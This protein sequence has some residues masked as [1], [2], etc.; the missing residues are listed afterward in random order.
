MT[1][2]DKITQKIAEE[3][4]VK[5]DSILAEA[6]RAAAQILADGRTEADEKAGKIIADANAEANR[7]TSAAKAKAESI[8]RTKY[9]EV[10]NAVVNDVIAAAFE[11]VENMDDEA[12][13]ALLHKLCVKNIEKGECELYL[14]ARDLKRLPADFEDGINSAVYETGAVHVAKQPKPI[15]NG[16]VLVYG[17]ME[18]N[19]T[20]R[21]VFDASMD[22]LKDLLGPMLFA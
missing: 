18:V 14:N 3:S 21:A 16:F 15:E 6:N 9:L 4:R 12:Y 22:S 5:V 13:F 8:T 19:C 11:A 17:D 7:I 10:K 1:G 20:L 2:L